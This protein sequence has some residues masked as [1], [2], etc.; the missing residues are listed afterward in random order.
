MVIARLLYTYPAS[1]PSPPMISRNSTMMK[2]VLRLFFAMARY[3]ESPGQPRWGRR[4]E[5]DARRLCDR[6]GIC[7]LE[8]LA[9][10]EPEAANEQ[11]VREGLDLRVELAHAAVVEPTG[12]LDL[13]FGV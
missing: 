11:G 4:L 5:L 10:F 9:L 3:M 6:R 8:E 12:G 2:I 13:V 7:D 1:R